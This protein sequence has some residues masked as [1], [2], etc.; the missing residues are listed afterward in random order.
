MIEAVDARNSTCTVLFTQF[1]HRQRA[2]PLSVLRPTASTQQQQHGAG[3]A[4]WP[5]G[6]A[7]CHYLSLL[8]STAPQT[9]SESLAAMM[10]AWYQSGFRTGY[11]LALQQQQAQQRMP[12]WR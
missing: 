5:E 11:H 10:M 3:A 1:N 6:D 9:E 12:S 8:M 7:V 2:T 4:Y